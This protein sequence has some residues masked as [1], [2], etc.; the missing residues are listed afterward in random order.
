MTNDLSTGNYP[1]LPSLVGSSKYSVFK[2]LKDRI[3]KRIHGWNAKLLSKVGKAVLLKSVAI[4][5]PSYCMTC[6][7]LAKKLFQE[8]ERILNGLWWSSS[9]SGIR[10]IQWM[11]WDKMSD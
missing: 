4:A 9:S 8:I 2:F 1:G 6:F 10:G 3:E 5:I 11:S 7:L